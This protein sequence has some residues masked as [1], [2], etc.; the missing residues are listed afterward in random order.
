MRAE[1]ISIIK[2]YCYS[3]KGILNPHTNKKE[4]WS[5]NNIEYI[6]DD[7]LDYTNFLSQYG[8]V[9][10]KQR[11]YHYMNSI[12]H[13][14]KCNCIDCINVVSWN[15]KYS[16]YCSPRCN[17]ISTT[18]KR[19]ET[20]LK[21]YG[22]DNPS[23]S[24]HIKEKIK[25]TSLDRYGVTNYAHSDE[26]KN[27]I[28][29]F[30]KTNKDEILASREQVNL[31]KYGYS[32]PFQNEAI[33]EKSKKTLLQNYGSEYPLQ[34]PKFLEKLKDT[35]L[36]KYG[37]KIY[38]QQHIS[39]EFLK[40][41]ENSEWFREL[42][43]NNSLKEIAEKYSI[44]Y[45]LLCQTLNKL[46]IDISKYSNGHAELINFLK[47]IIDCDILINDRKVLNGKELDCYIPSH[48]LAIEYN[49][50]YW[51]SEANGKY[52]NYHQEKTN[53]C[54]NKSIKLIHIFEN[55]WI[56]KRDIIESVLKSNLCALTNKVYARNCKI[57]ILT[58][59]EEQD[60][61]NKNHLQGYI[62]SNQCIG[63]IYND[64]IV[65]AMS[66]G[67]P[68]FNKKYDYELLR[69]A[70]SLNT[71]VTG[72]ASKLFSYF[73]KKENP[74]S[75]ISYGN[76][77]YFSGNIYQNLGFTFIRYTEPSYYYIDQY[78][79]L[80]NRMQFQKHKIQQK[81]NFY[82]DSLTEY[83]NMIQNGYN[84]IWDCGN[85]SWLWS[86]NNETDKVC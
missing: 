57:K 22:V 71:V 32:Y 43:K 73:I 19:K 65:Q 33:R 68:R 12:D 31:D 83:Q 78:G 67:V 39:P 59:K 28:G 52:K 60:F 25:Q 34:V 23:K 50:V 42:M 69:M 5:K 81:L 26:F 14:I 56:E 46:N 8:S 21:R 24:I 7:I 29:S 9:F 53:L 3:D 64:R 86:K 63:L 61:F 77:R 66:F 48:N 79:K 41:R 51:H 37:V 38:L 35:N 75:I 16:E 6:Y 76:R 80:H 17:S 45:S 20:S 82:D 13:L 84:R 10:M 47:T 40:N 36:Q 62:S 2:K 44:S 27:K 55:E 49:G 85:S 70:T 18:D 54:I 1:Y 58:K 72:G 4:W 15:G 30:W 74:N 11:L